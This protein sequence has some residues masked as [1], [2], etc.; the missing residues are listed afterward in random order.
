MLRDKI[1]H[2]LDIV[3]RLLL[4][5]EDPKYEEDDD[6]LYEDNAPPQDHINDIK[7]RISDILSKLSRLINEKT[8]IDEKTGDPNIYYE[9]DVQK[10]A[11]KALEEIQE[12]IDTY[13]DMAYIL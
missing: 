2:E 7:R 10:E 8:S 13:I 9:K 12:L 3:L 6:A 11:K 1:W 5:F 4:Y